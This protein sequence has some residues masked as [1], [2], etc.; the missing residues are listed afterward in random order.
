MVVS[1]SPFDFYL[2][3]AADDQSLSVDL[4]LIDLSVPETLDLMS[5][6]RT[7][8]SRQSLAFS[9]RCQ[10]RL[11]DA[12]RYNLKE[13]S[14]AGVTQVTLSDPNQWRQLPHRDVM[15]LRAIRAA[16]EY[17]I[18]VI[19]LL[20]EFAEIAGIDSN[21]AARLFHLSP[22]TYDPKNPSF[23]VSWRESL[24]PRSLTHARGPGFI[25]IFDQ[26][27]NS[28]FVTLAGLQYRLW[29]LAEGG[30]SLDQILE[31]GGG[32]RSTIAR[33]FTALEA[34]EL[35]YISDGFVVP[36]SLRRSLSESWTSGLQ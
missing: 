9:I 36:L 13:L 23:S 2:Q 14:T 17:A 26:R 12:T 15:V 29:Q 10:L 19:W 7:A 4:G 22:P 1:I 32:G 34:Q 27:N 6:F 31:V 18:E 3:R 11:S 5:N 28:R 24:L 21:Y 8:R 35:V 16:N 25:R 20:R 30:I 33:F